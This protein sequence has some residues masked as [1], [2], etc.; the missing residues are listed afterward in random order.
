MRKRAYAMM[1]KTYYMRRSI[2]P[3][4]W[5]RTDELVIDE[6]PWYEGG[7]KQLTYVKLTIV[8]NV[9]KLKVRAED[10]YIKGTV[11]VHNKAVFNDS[12]FEF[13]LTPKNEI[14]SD[15]L[16]FEINCLGTVYVA[17]NNADRECLSSQR[18]IGR[19]SIDSDIHD[20][21]WELVISIPIQMIQDLYGSPVNKKLW[22][23]NFYRCGGEKE[24]QYAVWNKVGGNKPDY[25]RPQDFGRILIGE[26]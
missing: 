24:T 9:L 14:Q 8:D 13:F 6:F 16:N 3:V 4:D 17:Y 11:K 1:K 7:L 5:E 22:Y 26:E 15:Y 23:A 2:E 12:C 10:R 18:D 19:I 20:D 25:H 21:V